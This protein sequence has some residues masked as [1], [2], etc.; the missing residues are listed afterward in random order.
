[1]ITYLSYV[2]RIKSFDSK[3]FIS[4][5]ACDNWNFRILEFR[6]VQLLSKHLK[7]PTIASKD[8]RVECFD[9]FVQKTGRK[10]VR[11]L[12]QVERTIQHEKDNVVGVHC[13][14]G[15][16]IVGYDHSSLHAVEDDLLNSMISAGLQSRQL[17]SGR[18]RE[19]HEKC[20]INKKSNE[21]DDQQR[22]SGDENAKLG[23]CFR[24][25]T[26]TNPRSPGSNW[27]MPVKGKGKFNSLNRSKCGETL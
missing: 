21:K 14:F 13:G 20:R 24:L 25:L 17:A 26:A 2:T 3:L 15:R 4:F 18:E 5:L 22:N 8:Q 12:A 1:M 27:R 19:L 16:R 9:L 23:Q 11:I 6:K 7:S 10:Y